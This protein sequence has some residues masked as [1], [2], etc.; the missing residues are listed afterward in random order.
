MSKPGVLSPLRVERRHAATVGQL[1][2][3]RASRDDLTDT[4]LS[5]LPAFGRK[6]SAAA[7]RAR[8]SSSIVALWTLKEATDG[9][10]YLALF[11]HP[12]VPRYFLNADEADAVREVLLST[13]MVLTARSG[14]KRLRRSEVEAQLFAQVAPSETQNALT[15]PGDE[16]WTRRLQQRIKREDALFATPVAT[17]P[18]RLLRLLSPRNTGD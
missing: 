4:P 1:I 13:A 11:Q 18:D 7:N 6:L 12:A 5:A 17:V 14:R 9:F 16:R 8:S 2:Q 3:E 15:E 10:H